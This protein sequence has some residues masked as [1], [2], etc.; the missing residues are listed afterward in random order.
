MHPTKYELCV[1]CLKETVI[2]HLRLYCNLDAEH[3]NEEDTTAWTN[4][5]APTNF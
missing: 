1:K 5:D 2:P 3:C 4:L